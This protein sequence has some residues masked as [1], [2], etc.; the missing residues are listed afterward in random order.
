MSFP[1]LPSI[2]LMHPTPVA[3]PFH[4]EGWV[5]E[6]KY[7]GWRMLAYKRGLKEQLVSRAGRDHTRRF[8]ALVAAIAKL[9][10]DSLILDGEVCI[11][12]Q[13]LISRF[14]SLTAPALATGTTRV[15]KPDFAYLDSGEAVVPAAVD[16][17]WPVSGPGESGLG[18]RAAA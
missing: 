16:D 10:P 14:N 1:D 18:D 2:D 17:P 11:F 12:D 15:I 9:A 6:E 7:D 5:Y 8:P 3:R 13:Q 4:H